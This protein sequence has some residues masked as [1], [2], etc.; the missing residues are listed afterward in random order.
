M[1]GIGAGLILGLIILI[2]A[3]PMVEQAIAQIRDAPGRSLLIGVAVLILVP[4]GAMLLMVT[5]IGIPV[6]LL[7]LLAFPLMLLVAWVVATLG[8]A[9]WLFNRSRTERSLLGR[10]LL[11]LAGLAAVTLIGVVPIVGVLV[12]LLVMLLGL[13]ALWQSLRIRSAQAPT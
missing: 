6:G 11:L 13:G 12:W 3:R 9:D 7:T 5:V 2:T 1:F 4:L 8:V 10:L